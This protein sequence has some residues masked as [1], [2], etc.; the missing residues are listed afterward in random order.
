MKKFGAF[1]LS[2][3]LINAVINLRHSAIMAKVGYEALFFYGVAA[4][5]FL[6]PCGLV[7]AMLASNNNR[8]GGVYAWVA[9]EFGDN[10]GML[11]IWSA[12]IDTVIAFPTML[13]YMVSII[14]SIFHLN[15]NIYRLQYFVT[16]LIILLI[17]SLICLRGIHFSKKLN[18]IGFILGTLAPIILI[19][20][21]TASWWCVGN[22]ININYHS[23]DLVPKH[24][25]DYS[26]LASVL[27]SYG[28]LQIIGYYSQVVKNQKVDFLVATIISSVAI[29]VITVV[30]SLSIAFIVPNN[31]ISL[32]SGVIDTFSTFFNYSN[33]SW[34]I[35]P[36]GIMLFIGSFTALCTWLYGPA[37]G[38]HVA[39]SNK[40]NLNKLSHLN[41][42]DSPA[43]IIYIQ[44]I[45]AGLLSYL[46]VFLPTINNAYWV[47]TVMTGQYA[48]LSYIYIF[49]AAI[50]F[51]SRTKD[52]KFILPRIIM[53]IISFIGFLAC[54][55]VFFISFL[56]PTYIESISLLKYEIVLSVGILI[57]ISIPTLVYLKTK[58]KKH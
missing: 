29:V 40:S 46:F 1:T 39:I 3:I 12:W 44:I 30:V 19:M 21:I 13:S 45:I 51:I 17:T 11:T 42:Y 57:Y 41:T 7:S 53:L 20:I 37:S 36:M 50:K 34:M 32:S 22:H 9:N 31:K 54:I 8:Q 18:L 2:I 23:S 35:Y 52:I 25:S 38:L 24:L 48:A 10:F 16:M 5:C 58:I 27:V 28:G 4:A 14:F 26:L 6:I 55:F 49:A 47:I 33:M 15:Q 43:T 56:P